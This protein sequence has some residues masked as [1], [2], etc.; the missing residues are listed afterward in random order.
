MVHGKSRSVADQ[1]KLQPFGTDVVNQSMQADKVNLPSEPPCLL[2][3]DDGFQ[4]L[5]GGGLVPG[6]LTEVAGEA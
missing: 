1:L 5:L 2:L 6:T 4:S 3:E